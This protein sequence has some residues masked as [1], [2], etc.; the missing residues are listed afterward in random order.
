MI[1]RRK[2]PEE[3]FAEQ[4]AKELWRQV[5]EFDE[6]MTPEQRERLKRLQKIRDS[7]WNKL[8]DRIG[9]GEVEVRLK[10]VDGKP[11]LPDLLPAPEGAR[12]PPWG[13]SLV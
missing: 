7:I 12:V 5:R 6:K 3:E 9:K 11:V 2:S 8:E 10:E 4:L 13:G 1:F